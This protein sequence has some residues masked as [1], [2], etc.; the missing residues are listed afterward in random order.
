MTFRKLALFEDC[1]ISVPR[2]SNATFQVRLQGKIA[3]EN[4][5][6]AYSF[7]VETVGH[8]LRIM[9][10]GILDLYP[11]VRIILEHCAEALPFLIHRI[12][13]R[14]K[15]ASP[16]IIWPQMK[17]MREYLHQKF[18]ATIAGVRSDNAF[19]ATLHVMGENRVM[20]SVNYPY[21]SNEEAAD[22]V[23]NL[24]ISENTRATVG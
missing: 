18:Y 17:T 4:A 19:R 1:I 7:G 24:E 6:T 3:L 12:D 8:A 9:C 11:S 15:M 22:W 10:S 21:E 13:E 5:Q 23:D 14:M 2:K 20:Y 16:G